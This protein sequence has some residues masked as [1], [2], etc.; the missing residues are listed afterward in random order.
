MIRNALFVSLLCSV[1]WGCHEAKLRLPY[2]GHYD[3][4]YSP[5]GNDTTYHR[6]PAFSYLNQDS[7]KVNNTTYKDQLWLVEFF[8][9]SC[10]TICPLMNHQMLR[11]GREIDPD[12]R[13]EMQFL[14]F[15]IDPKNDTPS[16]LKRYRDSHKLPKTRWDFL[17]GNEEETHRLGIHHFMVFAGKDSLSAGGYAH[18]GAF[19]LVDREGFVRGVYAVIN[20]DLSINEQ[21]YARM[22]KELKILYDEHLTTRK[23]AFL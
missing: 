8:F 13:R 2:L 21:E 5:S 14:S 17:T 23:K 9:S 19:T 12:I 15:S 3:V 20:F 16:R 1:F 6:I 18:S 11:L 22:V 4:V 10:P 7:V